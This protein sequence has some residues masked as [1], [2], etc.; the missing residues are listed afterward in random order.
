[1]K[2]RFVLL[3]CVLLPQAAPAP[4]VQLLGAPHDS[5]KVRE[6]VKEAPEIG[7]LRKDYFDFQKEYLWPLLNSEM[8]TIFGIKLERL[9]D[10]YVLPSFQSDKFWTTGIVSGSQPEKRHTDYYCVGDLGFVEFVFHQDG[11]RVHAAVVFFRP[12][13]DFVPLCSEADLA[14]RLAWEKDK[15]DKTKA[16]ILQHLPRKTSSNQTLE[17]T[18]DRR[19]NSLSMTS[20]LKSEALLALVSGRSA[21]SR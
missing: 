18:T 15:W 20:T 3:L 7:A 21:Y 8:P 13:A 19:L 10:D 1:M 6:S 17:R 5:K 11:E 9:P 16:W 4:I 14:G 12:D 2:S